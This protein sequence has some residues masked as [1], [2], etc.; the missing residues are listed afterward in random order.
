MDFLNKVAGEALK[1]QQPAQQQ[2]QEQVQTQTSGGLLGSIASAATQ[3]TQP[4]TTTTQQQPQQTQTS[5]ASGLFG[6]LVSSATQSTTQQQ[7]QQQQSGADTLL[8]KLHGA[9]GGGPESEKKEDALDK[10]IDLV[11][12]HVFKAG[13]QTNESAAE[14]AKDKFIADSIRNGYEKAT[15]KDFPIA[16]K[17]EEENKVTAGL[18]GFAGKLFK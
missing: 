5:G 14:Q 1:T 15:G 8:N 10:A 11:Q 3:S 4:A 9:V 13:P 16:A 7:P 2:K 12:E 18:S 17:K 6:S